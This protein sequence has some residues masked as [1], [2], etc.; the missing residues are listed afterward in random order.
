MRVRKKGF[1][2]GYL[3]SEDKFH[4]GGKSTKKG[5]RIWQRNM[6]RKLKREAEKMIRE[7]EA[8]E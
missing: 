7:Q 3:H 8:E 6:R 5:D 1:D 2:F 4:R